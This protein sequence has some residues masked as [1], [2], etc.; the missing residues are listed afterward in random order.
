MKQNR[1]VICAFLVLNGL[2]LSACGHTNDPNNEIEYYPFQ[3]EENGNYGMISPDGQILFSDMFDQQPT[4]AING[5]FLV[6]NSDDLW[7][8]YTAEEKPRKIGGEYL[9]A[10]LFYEDVAIVVEKDK[11]IQ[12]IDKEG[13]VK[14]TLDKINGRPI[15]ECSQFVNGLAQVKVDEYWG[16]VN[17][18]GEI[19]IQPEYI[20]LISNINGFVTGPHKKH[21]D[22]NVDKWTYSVFNNKGEEIA[23]VGPPHVSHSRHI[24]TSYRSDNDMCFGDGLFIA[25]DKDDNEISGVVNYK[26]E[27]VMKSSN[28]IN[29]ISENQGDYLIF[30]NDEGYGL[31]NLKGEILIR[32]KFQSLN[33]VGNNL[34]KACNYDNKEEVENEDDYED[35]EVYGKWN[36]YDIQGNKLSQDEYQEI[37]Y[38]HNNAD[39]TI[40]MIGEHDY[41]LL[42]RDGKERKIGKDIYQIY[43]LFGDTSFESDAIDIDESNKD[44]KSNSS[45]SEEDDVVYTA[46][47]ES[48]YPTGAYMD[49]RE[50]TSAYIFSEKKEGRCPT[51]EKRISNG[52]IEYAEDMDTPLTYYNLVYVGNN[53][54][55]HVFDVEYWSGKFIDKGQIL[56]TRKT[57]GAGNGTQVHIQGL[58][59]KGKA[60]PFAGITIDG[61][62]D[63]NVN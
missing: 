25:A 60:L 16:A 39:C 35:F 22:S 1:N 38:F 18:K 6:K 47:D 42:G 54:E 29:F 55:G 30:S 28:K 10:G 58:D 37:F 2:L 52:Y 8:Y 5:R 59:T 53:S 14:V 63:D 45:D 15:K 46:I 56:I 50:T 48:D 11:P 23:S 13:K 49:N 40:A 36:L 7:E 41:V 44:D 21:K 51:M 62:K 31:T 20:W 24:R 57:G 34:L 61:Y 43:Q 26:G 4:V 33:F 19:V 3:T 27:W 12:F 17:T 32:P 9:R